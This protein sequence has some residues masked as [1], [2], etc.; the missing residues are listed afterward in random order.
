MSFV[1]VGIIIAYRDTY[2]CI[3]TAIDI[4]RRVHQ[5]ISKEESVH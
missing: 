5:Y 2:I 3:N 1:Y 4:Q